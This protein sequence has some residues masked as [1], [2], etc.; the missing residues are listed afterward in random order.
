[1]IGDEISEKD[2]KNNYLFFWFVSW[3]FVVDF[4]IYVLLWWEIIMNICIFF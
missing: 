1:M 2:I 3:V 4:W